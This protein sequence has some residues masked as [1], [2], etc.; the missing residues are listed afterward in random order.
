MD[1][2]MIY[3]INLIAEMA[4]KLTI[5]KNYSSKFTASGNEYLS[6]TERI[7]IEDMNDFFV[8]AGI[9]GRTE[10]LPILGK[11]GYEVIEFEPDIIGGQYPYSP[12][13]LITVQAGMPTVTKTGA[14]ISSIEQLEA[15]ATRIIAASIENRFE[16]QCAQVY[17]KGTYTDKDGK[18][19][20][21][22]VTSEDPLNWNTKTKYSDEILKLCLDY[23][24]KHGEFPK[25]E[26]GLTVFNALK[27]EANDTRQNI[28]NVR[29]VYGAAP[30]LEVSG[31]RIDLLVDAKGVDN[32]LIETKDLIILS[33][34]SN[35]AV[36]Y[37]CLQYGDVKSNASKLVK[38]KVI[39][40][41]LRVE[42]MTGSSGLWG[43]SAPMPLLLNVN[44]FKRYKV[45]IA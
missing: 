10:I 12:T 29:F 34:P 4:K 30:Y 28:N 18:V 27:N 44:K 40:G 45:T 1:K 31:Q 23:Q 32:V 36:G 19:L 6:P 14:E 5:P 11:D 22:G 41:D 3:L 37:G 8:T 38:A 15:K 20:N 42:A 16:K 24:T 7:R 26:V 33:T 25:A 43:K 13:D 39:A 2:R 21:V 17:L 35:L 9:V